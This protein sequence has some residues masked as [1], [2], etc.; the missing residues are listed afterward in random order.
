MTKPNDAPGRGRHLMNHAANLV[1]GKE[2]AKGEGLVAEGSGRRCALRVPVD[3]QTTGTTRPGCCPQFILGRANPQRHGHGPFR[4]AGGITKP[5]IQFLA[6][7]KTQLRTRPLQ[8][9]M[10]AA[11]KGNI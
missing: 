10:D 1:G 11:G 6:G 8:G 3:N 7:L 5:L 2:P 9:S 4:G